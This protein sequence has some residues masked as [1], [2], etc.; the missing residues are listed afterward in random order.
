[1]A[2]YYNLDVTIHFVAHG[3]EAE[4]EEEAIENLFPEGWEGEMLGWDGKV[5]LVDED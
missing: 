3:I 4:S 2:K 5:E 1:M